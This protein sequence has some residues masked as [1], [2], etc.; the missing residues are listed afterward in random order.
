ME[1]A[2]NNPR[3]ECGNNYFYLHAPIK[4]G[5]R[6]IGWSVPSFMWLNLELCD[7]ELSIEGKAD[8]S[9]HC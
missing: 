4:P 1:K 6:F 8:K 7:S 3:H 9:E 2:I 5:Y